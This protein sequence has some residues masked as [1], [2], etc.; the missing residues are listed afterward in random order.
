MGPTG[1]YRHQGRG[2]LGN[3]LVGRHLMVYLCELETTDADGWCD[4]SPQIESLGTSGATDK[5]PHSPRVR[6]PR[7][8]M[9]RGSGNG[10]PSRGGWVWEGET[11]LHQGL[12]A[13]GGA[14]PRGVSWTFCLTKSTDLN[15]NILP[16]HALPSFSNTQRTPSTAL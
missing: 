11:L 9:P 2:L 7:V 6:E 15:G 12:S 13:W 16:G 3:A 5:S 8:L 1:Q 4:S 14:L 10:H